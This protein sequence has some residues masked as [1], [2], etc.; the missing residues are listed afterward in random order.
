MSKNTK[1]LYCILGSIILT[2]TGIPTYYNAV[3]Y[4][5]VVGVYLNYLIS[6]ISVIG[7]ILTIYFAIRLIK[8]NWDFK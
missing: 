5:P 7:L 4:I 3:S 1:L 6:L 2:L 8:E